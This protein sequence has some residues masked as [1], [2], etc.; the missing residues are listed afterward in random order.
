MLLALRAVLCL[1]PT[2]LVASTVR[3]ADM[4][5]E[6]IDFV[7]ICDMR[8]EGYF[9]IPGTQTCL[10]L[11]GRVRT[12]YNVFF[13]SD[14]DFN[15]QPAQGGDV[16]ADRYRLRARG[17]TD[18]DTRS[19][20]EF[21]RLRTYGEIRLTY[22]YDGPTV[23]DLHKGFIELGGV[24]LGR[25]ISY[26]DF[27]GVQFTQTEFFDPQFSRDD[28][29]L[30]AAYKASLPGR[31]SLALSVEDTSGRQDGIT[32][33]TLTTD[34]GGAQIPDIV[35]RFQMG[36]DVDPSYWQL[37][38]ASH[39][40]N[41][42]TDTV[43]A[44]GEQMGFAVGAGLATDV[45]VG[46]NTRVGITSSFARGALSFATTNASAPYGLDTD[47]VF[48]PATNGVKLSNYLTVA[49]GGRTAIAP[50]WEFAFQAG[51]LFGD[52]GDAEVD[53][54]ND[55]DTDNLDYINVDLQTFVGFTPVSGFLMGVGSEFRYVEAADFG[56]ASFLTLYF[57]AQR[58]F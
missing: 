58:T 30:L 19:L 36:E 29:Q 27:T 6:P 47:G 26:Y 8:G 11:G 52:P 49:A 28:P 43:G 4:L 15:F 12:D 23:I 24:R 34:Y 13:N 18:W 1:V 39:Y 31:A 55:G 5:P 2:V 54:D 22:D 46:R 38:A 20:T 10:R 33:Q 50:N 42:V 40:V 21:G 37:M 16:T 25:S 35:V 14:R 44:S 41:T 56:Q 57:R 17:W 3:A 9:V 7:Q 51:F 45:P 32:S 53:F 48:D